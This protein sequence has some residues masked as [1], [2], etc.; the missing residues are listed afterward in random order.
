MI[1]YRGKYEY[2]GKFAAR[3]D[4][5]VNL[6]PARL[7][8]VLL[9][10]T[11]W[12]LGGKIGQGWRIMR[13]DAANTPSPNGG[14]PMAAMAGLLGVRLDKKGVYSLGDPLEPLT[15]AKVRTAWRIVVASGALMAVLCG[16]A[17]AAPWLLDFFCYNYPKNSNLEG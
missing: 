13:R 10:A 11:G 3:L 8:A 5:L 6:I 7:T 9:L 1:G 17:L 16:L 12:L 15:P 2:L 14:R 4:D